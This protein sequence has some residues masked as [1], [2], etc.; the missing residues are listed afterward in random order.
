MPDIPEVPSRVQDLAARLAQPRPMRRGSLTERRVKCGKPG[1]PCA[2]RPEARHGPY[3][4]LTRAVSGRTSTRLFI[5]PQA[6]GVRQQIEAGRR[7]RRLVEEFW[8]ACEQWANAELEA[9]SPQGEE[10][11]GSRRSSRRR[12]PRRSKPS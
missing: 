9:A 7:F 6:T 8:E 5:A 10:K 3:F 11:G 1:C 2:D 4:S 12:S